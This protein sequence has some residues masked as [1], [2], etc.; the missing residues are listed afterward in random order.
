MTMPENPPAL[1]R[2]SPR[3]HRPLSCRAYGYPPPPPAGY[4]P[5]PGYAPYGGQ[6]MPGAPAYAQYARPQG[7]I[8]G[9]ARPG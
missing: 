8:R 1:A 2:S 4:A 5:P 6:P 3:H 7:P 9:C